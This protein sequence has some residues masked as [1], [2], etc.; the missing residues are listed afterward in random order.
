LVFSPDEGIVLDAAEQM[1]RGKKLYVDFYG[2]MSPGSFWLQELVFRFLGLSLR[3]GRII[4][5]L[6]FALQCAL[7]F[8][9]IACAG[10]QKTGW[11]ATVLFFL[12]EA[13]NST[14]LLPGHRWDSA[15]LSLLSVAL[16]LHGA[17]KERPGWWIAGGAIISFAAFC[18]P[19]IAELAGI[20]ALAL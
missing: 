16:C 17:S 11:A 19:S 8:W 14:L 1:L 5:V 20:T 7:V 2:N 18:T 9:L 3:A 12:F 15:A 6:D 13:G 4:V 10:H